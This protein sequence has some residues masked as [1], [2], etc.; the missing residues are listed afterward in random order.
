MDPDSLPGFLHYL[1][2]PDAIIDVSAGGHAG[3]VSWSAT[4][5]LRSLLRTPHDS[6]RGFLHLG[7]DGKDL[8]FTYAEGATSQY[9]YARRVLFTAP[10]TID[11]DT[12]KATAKPLTAVPRISAP[13]RWAVGCGLAAVG[14]VDLDLGVSLLVVR[15]SDGA[16]WR[17][18]PKDPLTYGGIEALGVTCTELI[19]TGKQGLP[20]RIRLDSLGDPMP[21]LAPDI[22]QYP[23]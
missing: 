16:F 18:W 22:Q 12:L 20:T 14:A 3:F 10:Y 21:P 1:H 15:L 23:F 2:G 7:S 11:P 5:G 17:K 9:V 13:K 4:A 8:A 19:L 6:S